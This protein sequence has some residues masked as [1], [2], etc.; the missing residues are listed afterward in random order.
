[1]GMNELNNANN[2]SVILLNYSHNYD[3]FNLE[4]TDGLIK[5]GTPL[6]SVY[7]NPLG[8]RCNTK[9]TENILMSFYNKLTILN[10]FSVNEI[11]YQIISFEDNSPI[12]NYASFF[13]YYGF[14]GAIISSIKKNHNKIINNIKEVSNNLENKLLST[15]SF[16]LK[17][18][19]ISEALTN[20]FIKIVKTNS[21][22]QLD[23][24]IRYDKTLRANINKEFIC[25]RSLRPEH[26]T[27][28]SKLIEKGIK[29]NGWSDENTP[30]KCP[31]CGGEYIPTP[32]SFNNFNINEENEMIDI[33]TKS[34]S[35]GHDIA[36]IINNI[37]NGR[38]SNTI[39]MPERIIINGKEEVLIK[40]ITRRQYQLTIGRDKKVNIHYTTKNLINEFS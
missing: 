20:L 9:I 10:Y 19:L 5:F 31:T 6:K 12:I 25:S 22:E 37:F 3:N 28:L 40:G 23:E 7:Q 33:I 16:E 27:S 1:M 11:N 2:I 17:E 36:L 34:F 21:Y 13:N 29:V 18:L 39:I 24:R 32:I 4:F 26:K 30:K 14:S 8:E 35:L 15:N 38:L